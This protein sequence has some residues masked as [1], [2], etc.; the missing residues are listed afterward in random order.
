MTK[1]ELELIS[2]REKTQEIEHSVR[3]GLACVRPHTV[4]NN[5]HG[6]RS[7][8]QREYLI[9]LIG[10]S[11]NFNSYIMIDDMHSTMTK[12]SQCVT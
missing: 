1:A 4:A 3:G 8:K 10:Y 6:N 7:K 9:R 5:P 2:N 11:D 12:P